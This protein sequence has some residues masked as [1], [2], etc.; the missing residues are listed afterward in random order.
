MQNLLVHTPRAYFALVPLVVCIAF[1]SP[2]NAWA[3]TCSPAIKDTSNTCGTYLTGC[4]VFA[5]GDQDIYPN[6]NGTTYWPQSSSVN[7]SSYNPYPVYVSSSAWDGLQQLNSGKGLLAQVGWTHDT[8][9]Y[10]EYAFAQWTDN[11]GTF[12][13]TH[14]FYTTPSGTN[15]FSVYRTSNGTFDLE[16]NGGYFLPPSNVNWGPDDVAIEGEVGGYYSGNGDHFAG[17]KTTPVTFS[18]VHWGDQFGN[19][20]TANLSYYG[21]NHPAQFPQSPSYGYIY[22]WNGSSF[23]TWDNRCS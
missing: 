8:T 5:G 11:N 21:G 3:D 2:I 10:N 1:T 22:S 23:E 7:I 14:S 20:H 19:N 18:G 12:S 4:N 13:L 9:S 17:N 16:W 15:T 6:P